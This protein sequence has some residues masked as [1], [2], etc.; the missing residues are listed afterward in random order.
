M[1][2]RRLGQTDIEVSSL[3]LGTMMY[4]DQIVENDAFTQMDAC[5]DRGINFF[6]TAELYTIPPKPETRGNSER[7]VGNWIK[8]RGTRDKIILASKVVGRSQN[9]WIRDGEETRLTPSQM[10]S[11]LNR[12]LEILQTDYLDLYQLHWPDRKIGSFGST[13]RGYR[14]YDEDY[15]SYKE[16]LNTLNGFVKEGKVRHIGLSNETPYGTMRFVQTA[17]AHSLPRVHSIQNAYNLLNREFETG[18]AEVALEEKVGLLAYSPMAQGML[19]GKYLDGNLPE[20]SRGQLFGRLKRYQTP[21][22]EKAIRA[23]IALA[24][25]LDVDPSALANQFVTTRKFVTSNIFGVSSMSQL[26]TIWDSLE[27]NWTDEIESAINDIHAQG[28]NPC[29]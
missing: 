25:E 1:E 6:D 18:L 13:L 29:P 16:I 23:Y 26:E 8:A 12:S 3:C 19:S 20:G 24:K 5:L 17:T 4:G 21:G 15:V 7:I 22:A 2:K 28:P 27:I 11:A 10:T 9:T 14:H